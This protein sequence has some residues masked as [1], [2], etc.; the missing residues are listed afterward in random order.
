MLKPLQGASIY[1]ACFRTAGREALAEVLRDAGAEVFLP[2]DMQAVLERMSYRN[3]SL[4]VADVA[5]V[6]DHATEFFSFPGPDVPVLA[7][8]GSREELSRALDMGADEVY[9]ID[10]DTR[11]L[12]H[13]AQALS[14]RCACHSG[15]VLCRRFEEE[16]LKHV[17]KNMPVLVYACDDDGSIVFFNPEFERLTGYCGQEVLDNPEAI[18]LIVPDE[19]RL[20]AACP[21]ERPRLQV[22]GPQWTFRDKHGMEKVIAWSHMSENCP[23]RGWSRW[24]VGVD[25]TDYNRLETLRREVERTVQH[26]L[27]N[28]LNAILGFSGLLLEDDA[29]S[30]SVRDLVE[31]VHE[32]SQRMVRIIKGSLALFRIEQG[33]RD[34]LPVPVDLNAMLRSIQEEAAGMARGRD[35]RVTFSSVDDGKVEIMGEGA[36]LETLFANLVQNAVEASPEGRSV[37]IVLKAGDPVVVTVHNDGAIPE[38][39]RERFFERYVSAKP[40][41]TGLGTFLAKRIALLH[42]GEVSFVS[43]AEQGTTLRVELS[44]GAA[45]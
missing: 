11:L 35:V 16:R 42:G 36:L 15:H 9:H 27:R 25:V 12:V 43:T 45:V 29:V 34:L 4:L 39:V 33:N 40:G 38:T 22:P 19:D 23:I 2:R 28:P 37:D 24:A 26:D 31:R 14:H 13:R 10:G 17:L 1:F 6:R 44:A 41:G 20:N 30:G 18:S 21:I 3:C 5:E 7:V 8:T 32:C